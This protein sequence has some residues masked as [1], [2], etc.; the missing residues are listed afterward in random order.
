M[1]LCVPTSGIE[2]FGRQTLMSF[3]IDVGSARVT[4]LINGGTNGLADRRQLLAT[5]KGIWG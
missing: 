1:P 3:T 4:Q 5:A 2:L